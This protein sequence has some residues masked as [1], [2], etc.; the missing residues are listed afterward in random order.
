[1]CSIMVAMAKG[2]MVMQAVISKLVSTPL[3]KR[4]KTVASLWTGMPIQS[5]AATVWTTLAREAGSTIMDT[6]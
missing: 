2:T 4:P 3:A 6:R 5:A 1:M